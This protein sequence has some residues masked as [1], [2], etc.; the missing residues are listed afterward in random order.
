MC[1][2]APERVLRC[3]LGGFGEDFERIL[4]DISVSFREDF[5]RYFYIFWKDFERISV[6]EN[7][8][9]LCLKYRITLFKILDYCVWH[10]GV[11][12]LKYCYVVLCYVML[13]YSMLWYVMLLYVCYVMLCHVTLCAGML[14]HAM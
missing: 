13:C 7:T 11:L 3:Y 6:F 12:C 14:C 9:L 8:G 4:G 5:R 1:G 2:S 10:T